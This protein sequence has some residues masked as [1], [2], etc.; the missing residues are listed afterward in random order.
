MQPVRISKM[1]SH[2]ALH[3]HTKTFRRV[4]FQVLRHEEW[5]AVWNSD[6]Q[7]RFILIHILFQQFL[8]AGLQTV[9]SANSESGKFHQNLRINFGIHHEVLH[10]LFTHHDVIQ[11]VSIF[12][13]FSLSPSRALRHVMLSTNLFIQFTSPEIS[14]IS[15]SILIQTLL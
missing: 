10:E 5:I 13:L 11:L 1:L 2:V 4:S 9:P 3:H 15:T 12:Q 7:P 14:S 6:Q 8:I